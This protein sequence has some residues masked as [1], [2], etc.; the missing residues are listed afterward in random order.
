[1]SHHIGCT[2]EI[3]RDLLR[4]LMSKPNPSLIKL[5]S[6]EVEPGFGIFIN[7]TQVAWEVNCWRTF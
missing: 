7:A 2:L 5:D 4:A 6:I 1:M 3:S